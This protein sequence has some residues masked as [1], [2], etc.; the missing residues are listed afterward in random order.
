M[1]VEYEIDR[2]R[3]SPRVKGSNLTGQRY[4]TG[5]YTLDGAVHANSV[6][7]FYGAPAPF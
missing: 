5:G 2:R 4:R 6:V 1:I 3:I 7:G